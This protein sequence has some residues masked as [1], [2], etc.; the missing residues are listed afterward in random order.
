MR[1]TTDRPVMNDPIN[2]II[3]ESKTEQ[4]QL[5]ELQNEIR[6]NETLLRKRNAKTK[7]VI[8]STKLKQ[9]YHDEIDSVKISDISPKSKY[10][11]ISTYEK[12]DSWEVSQNLKI[13]LE[14]DRAKEQRWNDKIE[15]R[16]SYP[17][18]TCSL[19]H[20]RTEEKKVAS[21]S[22]QD[23]LDA[24]K[25][26]KEEGNDFFN[27]G[28]YTRALQL[29]ENVLNYY[30][31]CFCNTSRQEKEANQL[32]LC[33]LLNAAICFLKQNQY[34]KAI[35]YCT[36]AIQI[37]P[38]N[39]KARF[40]RA[41]AYRHLDHFTKAKEDLRVAL[42]LQGETLKGKIICQEILREEAMLKAKIRSYE[43]TRKDIAKKMW[44]QPIATS[45]GSSKQ[46]SQFYRKN[47]ENQSCNINSNPALFGDLR[48]P[49]EEFVDIDAAECL[50]SKLSG[51]DLMD[52]TILKNACKDELMQLDEENDT[53]DYSWVHAAGVSLI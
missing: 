13:Q 36:Q 38:M 21:M 35:E 3:H 23:R 6:K 51:I 20:D 46:D 9:K 18:T 42:K 31:Y 5:C 2:F 27:E 44:K 29:Y 47:N 53:N 52:A 25:S 24:M 16:S 37:Q 22:T 28:Q 50:V 43:L 8:S 4:E 7:K 10:D 11:W 40:R 12:W 34:E 48:M 17:S 39:V 14:R 26:F 1:P 41:Q 15:R 19:S 32:R 30:E 45:K 49:L 33:A